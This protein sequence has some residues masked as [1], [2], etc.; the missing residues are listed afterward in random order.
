MPFTSCTDG[1]ITNSLKKG[2]LRLTRTLNI[3]EFLFARESL[4][5]PGSEDSHPSPARLTLALPGRL[6]KLSMGSGFRGETLRG[7]PLD[8]SNCRLSCQ[9]EESGQSEKEQCGDCDRGDPARTI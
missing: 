8:R 4:V 5:D 6:Q 3:Q 7:R 2:A 9:K 1:A